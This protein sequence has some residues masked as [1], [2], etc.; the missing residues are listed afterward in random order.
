MFPVL[1]LAYLS[2]PCTADLKVAAV[3]G[4]DGGSV[5]WAARDS[6]AAGSVVT[7]AGGD[8]VAPSGLGVVGVLSECDTLQGPLSVVRGGHGNGSGTLG[9]GSNGKAG[10]KSGG[11]DDGEL[12]FEGWVWFRG[13]VEVLL[14]VCEED[15]F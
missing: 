12:H 1:T 15:V 4:V 14:L 9:W 6:V 10:E 13:D 5:S 2:A 8:V 3:C 11:E 7:A